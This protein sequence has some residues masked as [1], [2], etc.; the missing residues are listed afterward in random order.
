MQRQ[1]RHFI[2]AE[3]KQLVH[4]VEQSVGV[5]FDCVEAPQGLVLRILFQHRLHG[6]QNQ[7]EG[8]AQLMAEIGEEPEFQLI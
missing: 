2:L 7:R 8:R 6:R 5:D 4:E 1:S 3:I